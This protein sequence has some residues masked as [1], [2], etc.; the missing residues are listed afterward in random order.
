MGVPSLGWEDPLEVGHGNS[1]QYS[2]LE[3]PMDRGAWWA[4]VHG[5]T[6]T[7]NLATEQNQGQSQDRLPLHLESSEC[8]SPQVLPGARRLAS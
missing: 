4:T 2:C 1:L 6:E 3:H 7:H 8:A 5:V